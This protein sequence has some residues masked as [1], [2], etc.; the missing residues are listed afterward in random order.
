MVSRTLAGPVGVLRPCSQFCT[1]L[2]LTPIMEAKFPCD[3]ERFSRM[4]RISCRSTTNRLEGSLVPR[5]IS[6]PSRTLSRS[7]LK[8]WLFILVS[9]HN[10][11]KDGKLPLR[12]IG[13]LILWIDIEHEDFVACVPII[14]DSGSAAFSTARASP[15]DFSETSRMLD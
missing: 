8:S 12:Q 5:S 2:I 3:R 6:R 9:L 4:S 1:V 15:S 10:G 13:A 14:D 7:W 11:S